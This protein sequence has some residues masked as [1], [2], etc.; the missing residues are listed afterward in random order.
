MNLLA[1]SELHYLGRREGLS[2]AKEGG[3]QGWDPLAVDLRERR[4]RGRWHHSDVMFPGVS[5]RPGSRPFGT[6]SSGS[7]HV[8]AEKYLTQSRT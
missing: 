1:E 5:R 3:G 4:G 2:E 8:L 7:W 6:G